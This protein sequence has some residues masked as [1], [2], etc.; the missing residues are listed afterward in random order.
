[1]FGLF[2]DSPSHL[3]LF[4]SLPYT[5]LLGSM[6][7]PSIPLHSHTIISTVGNFTNLHFS[8]STLFLV[9]NVINGTFITQMRESSGF[10]VYKPDFAL[11]TCKNI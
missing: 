6:A 11:N 10:L 2:C 1:M 8:K 7:W 5:L 9:D 3:T 4:P